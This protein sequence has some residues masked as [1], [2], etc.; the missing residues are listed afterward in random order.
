MSI[1]QLSN[2][3]PEF[4][5][6]IK[7]NLQSVLTVEGAPGLNLEQIN[8]IALSC[9]YAV[10]FKSLQLVISEKL[11]PAQINAAKASAAI[12]A[13]NNVYYRFL[14]LAEDKEFSTMPAKLRMSVI[15]KPGIDKVDFELMCL[16]VSSISGCG[17]CIN[18]HIKEVKKAGISSEG[19]QSAIRIAAVINAASTALKINEDV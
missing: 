2:S 7:L 5:K 3:I 9:A 16:A 15:G 11:T 1:E 14:H 10:D 12:M 6:D 4:A 17:A 13:M 18:S 19:A 8:T